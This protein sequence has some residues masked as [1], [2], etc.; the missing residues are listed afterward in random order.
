VLATGKNEPVYSRQQTNQK[1]TELYEILKSR[2]RGVCIRNLEKDAGSGDEHR[3][4]LEQ[5]VH[6]K[7]RKGE[8]E[9]RGQKN[10]R[11]RYRI[12][13]NNRERLSKSSTVNPHKGPQQASK[14]FRNNGEEV[15]NDETQDYPVRVFFEI[16]FSHRVI[17]LPKGSCRPL[18]SVLIMIG[19]WFFRNS[20][21]KRKGRDRAYN[22]TVWLKSG[23][24]RGSTPLHRRTSQGKN[25]L[26]ERKCRL[27][28]S[29]RVGEM[30]S[31]EKKY[32]KR[33]TIRRGKV[34]PDT[35]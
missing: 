34:S 24:G 6:K 8:F 23:A 9:I 4:I 19:Y 26:G 30:H 18:G 10:S 28:V 20:K 14:N 21:K 13:K 12:W 31:L 25:R 29:G 32:T 16:F 11:W 15:E 22:V 27:L 3:C 33:T 7:R 2:E 17:I 1:W 5:A 35:R